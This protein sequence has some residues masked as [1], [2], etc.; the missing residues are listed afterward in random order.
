[1]F[2]G[3]ADWHKVSGSVSSSLHAADIRCKSSWLVSFP[4]SNDI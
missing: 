3:E 2:G 4:S 1:M